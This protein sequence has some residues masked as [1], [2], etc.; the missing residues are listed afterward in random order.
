M[1]FVC[2]SI[3]LIAFKCLWARQGPFPSRPN[4]CSSDFIRCYRPAPPPPS[5][6]TRVLATALCVHASRERIGRISSARDTRVRLYSA[7]TQLPHQRRRKREIQNPVLDRWICLPKDIRIWQSISRSHT[8]ALRA[9]ALFR[10]FL[11][12]SCEHET[13]LS[14]S[15]FERMFKWRSLWIQRNYYAVDVASCRYR[16]TDCLQLSNRK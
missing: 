7:C 9:I 2:C 5:P 10:F 16:C 13:L 4:M 1:M 12:L 15:F 8:I 6:S 3:G 11:R 14:L